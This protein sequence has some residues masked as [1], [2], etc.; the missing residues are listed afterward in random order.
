M[1]AQRHTLMILGLLTTVAV[2]TGCDLFTSEKAPR[3]EE[4]IIVGTQVPSDFQTTHRFGLVALPL[5]DRGEAILSLDVQSEVTIEMP[6]SIDASARIEDV[7]EPSGRPLALALDIDAS[8]SMQD[9]DPT[10]ARLSGAKAFVDVLAQSGTSF[11]TAVFE[12]S[13]EG[14]RLL[15]PFTGDVDSLRAAIDQIGSNGG[16]PTYQGLLQVLAV[17]DSE[18]PSSGFD[19]SIVLFSD[20][21]PDDTDIGLREQ[22]CATA[23]TA[24]APIYAIGLGPASDIDGNDP[25]AVEEMRAIAECTGA[26]YTGIDPDDVEGSTLLIFNNIGLATSQGSIAFDVQLDGAE[27]ASLV[28]GTIV[29]GTL[30][31]T[32]GGTSASAPFSFRVP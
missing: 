1:K 11:E 23:T 32:S 29:Q 25:T 13:G 4:I 6:A 10:G 15:Q 24:E 16:T 7:T 22:V 17:L 18:K 5:D 12:Y 26:A 27:L 19:R 8:G 21:Q 31:I 28:E 3:V 14:A 2:M 9:N 30:T 20:G